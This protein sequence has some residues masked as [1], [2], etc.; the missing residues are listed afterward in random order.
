MFIGEKLNK[1]VAVSGVVT[2]VDLDAQLV[3]LQIADRNAVDSMKREFSA[4]GGFRFSDLEEGSAFAIQPG[5]LV[6]GYIDGNTEPYFLCEK[7][8]RETLGLIP[9]KLHSPATPMQAL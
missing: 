1:P 9:Y 2:V 6:T 3:G 7:D 8:R 5:Q 4:L